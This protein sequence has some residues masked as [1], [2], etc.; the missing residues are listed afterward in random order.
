MN[1][2]HIFV[3]LTRVEEWLV[4]AS[5]EEEAREKWSEGEMIG[6][7]GD[8]PIVIDLANAPL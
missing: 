4:A 7:E 1:K 5:T 3:E 2:Y 6:V 8:E